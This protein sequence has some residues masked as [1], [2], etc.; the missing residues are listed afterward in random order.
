[1]RKKDRTFY[2]QGLLLH[3]LKDRH[4]QTDKLALHPRTAYEL[5]E[6]FLPII[7]DEFTGRVPN[8]DDLIADFQFHNRKQVPLE[9]VYGDL[10]LMRLNPERQLDAI[11]EDDRHIW[12]KRFR[13]R[14]PQ[15]AGTFSVSAPGFSMD[16]SHG[17]IGIGVS[18]GTLSGSGGWF[19]YSNQE[20]Q[21]KEV[22][23]VPWIS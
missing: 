15:L 6:Q 12:W 14:F 4:I 5:H 7:R 3:L 11:L 2:A 17:M 21:W 19:V 13:E 9:D 18:H 8:A 16:Y 22:G 20:S 23:S 1:M 10:E